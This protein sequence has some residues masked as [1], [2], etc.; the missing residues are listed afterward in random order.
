LFLVA[1]SISA[2]RCAR[3]EMVESL[4]SAFTPYAAIAIVLT[5]LK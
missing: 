1:G 4:I 3:L 2:K 5:R